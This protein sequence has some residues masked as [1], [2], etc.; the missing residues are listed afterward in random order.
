MIV[1]IPAEGPRR[2]WT[3]LGNPCLSVYVPGFPPSI[4]PELESV[5]Q[6]QRFAGLR[7]RIEADPAA[8]ASTEAVLR[9]VEA[10][11]WEEADAAG[12]TGSR[13]HLD[14]FTRGAY[15]AVD[16]ALHRLGV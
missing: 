1:D 6:W 14:R 11:L 4:A 13:A 12:A 7:D 16:A 5:S 2:V 8:R 10:E 15:R 3:A 9:A